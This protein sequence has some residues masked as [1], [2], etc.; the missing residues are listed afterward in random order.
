MRNREVVEQVTGSQI[1]GR[2]GDKLD[3]LHLRIPSRSRVEGHPQPVG[4]GRVCGILVRRAQGEVVRSG[5]GT[6]DVPLVR[7]NFAGPGPCSIPCSGLL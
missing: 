2:L 5:L 3:S 4:L 1:R 7:A 6:V